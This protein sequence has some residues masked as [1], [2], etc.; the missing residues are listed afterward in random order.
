MKS[1]GLSVFMNVGY[2]GGLISFVDTSEFVVPYVVEVDGN[3][4]DVVSIVGGPGLLVLST[5][6]GYIFVVGIDPLEY[7]DGTF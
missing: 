2:V 7:V 6:F 5:V 1:F 3:R 4:S